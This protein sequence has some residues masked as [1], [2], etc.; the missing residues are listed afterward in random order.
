M[1]STHGDVEATVIREDTLDLVVTGHHLV[2]I[3]LLKMVATEMPQV[4]DLEGSRAEFMVVGP[5][6]AQAKGSKLPLSKVM[7]GECIASVNT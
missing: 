5:L 6:A 4:G 1:R 7:H 3:P 2:T